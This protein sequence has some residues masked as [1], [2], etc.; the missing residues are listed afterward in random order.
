MTLKR[1][2]LTH[3]KPTAYSLTKENIEQLRLRCKEG[4][5]SNVAK[6]QHSTFNGYRS[7]MIDERRTSPWSRCLLC[8]WRQKAFPLEINN[9]VIHLLMIH[10]NWEIS[11]NNFEHN[12]LLQKLYE[13]LR[14]MPFFDCTKFQN[15]WTAS[16]K[17]KLRLCVYHWGVW[18]YFGHFRKTVH[19]ENSTALSVLPRWGPNFVQW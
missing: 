7:M 6:V 4:R 5:V 13:N 10:Q 9:T 12:L 11:F 18:L 15:I 16:H 3:S 2:W 19:F 8:T 14:Y 17:E 1:G